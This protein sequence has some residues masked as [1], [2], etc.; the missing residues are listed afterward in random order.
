MI[1]VIPGSFT[2][3]IVYK[4]FFFNFRIFVDTETILPGRNDQVLCTPQTKEEKKNTKNYVTKTC[5]KPKLMKKKISN[6]QINYKMNKE[7]IKNKEPIEM[8][9]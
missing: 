9:I 6:V 5:I 1:H 3:F 4:Y 8:H 7:T 2:F